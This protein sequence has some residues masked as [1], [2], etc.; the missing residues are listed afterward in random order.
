VEFYLLETT[1]LEKAQHKAFQDMGRKHRQWKHTF[2]DALNIQPGNMPKRSVQ[3][4]MQSISH[5]M[6]PHKWII[7][8][9]N[10]VVRKIRY[11]GHDLY[12][13][14]VYFQSMFN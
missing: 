14:Y 8:W 4:C 1:D 7:C 11:V 12:Y 6:T 5:N 10:G 9:G 2:K 3:E 13:Y